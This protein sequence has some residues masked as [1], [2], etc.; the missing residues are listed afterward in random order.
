MLS[1]RKSFSLLALSL[2]AE[3]A[4]T[5]AQPF[6]VQLDAPTL[7]RWNYPFNASPGF[8][9]SAS[10]F[11]APNDPLFDDR[12][13]Q[14]LLGFDTGGVVPTGAGAP[15]YIVTE[16]V[17]TVT[18][19]SGGVFAYDP[20]VD[21]YTTLLEETDPNFTPDADAGRPLELFGVGFRNGF[22]IDT[23]LEDSPFQQAPFGNWQGTRN[24]FPTDFLLGDPRDISR[25]VEFGFTPTP[26]AIGLNEVLSPGSTVQANATFTFTLDLGNPDVAAYLGEALNAGKLRLMLTSLHPAPEM[27]AGA[28]TFPDSYTRENKFSIPFGFAATLDRTV[29]ISDGP[30]ADLNGDGFVNGADLATLLSQWGGPGD[31]DLN[32]DGTVDGTDLAQLLANWTG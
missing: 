9:T 24:A 15:N 17:V 28:Q 26:F 25:H 23:F 16:A 6:V 19:S 32:G 20:T 21:D 14:F 10:T 13:A 5:A 8:R 18:N 4:P 31:A 2:T 7:D 11:G 1:T 27:G 12:D 30:A 3:A 22:T 29:E